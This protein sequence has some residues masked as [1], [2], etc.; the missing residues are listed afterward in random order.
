MANY[1]LSFGEETTHTADG[2]WNRYVP[3]YYPEKGDLRL[4]QLIAKGDNVTFSFFPKCNL[5]KLIKQYYVGEKDV[6]ICKEKL[7]LAFAKVLFG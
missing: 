7:N 1:V 6:K 5:G 3:V 4:G 2:V